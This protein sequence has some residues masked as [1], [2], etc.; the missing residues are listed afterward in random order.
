MFANDLKFEETAV[1]G[2]NE[3]IVLAGEVK[4]FA[5]REILESILR[6]EDGHINGIEEIRDQIAQMGLQIFLTTQVG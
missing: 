5:T 6:D 2:Y 1:K 3:G 4:D